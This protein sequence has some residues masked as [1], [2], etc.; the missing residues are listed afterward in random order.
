MASSTAH[1][2]RKPHPCQTR[3]NSLWC[4]LT[5]IVKFCGEFVRS[6][7][8]YRCL[9]VCPQEVGGIPPYLAGHM[10][11]QQYISSCIVVGS[12]LVWRLHTCNIKWWDRSHGRPP[13]HAC[14]PYYG[15]WSMSGRHASYWN[16]FLLKSSFRTNHS[17][18]ET[19]SIW[20]KIVFRNYP[21]LNRFWKFFG[22]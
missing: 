5:L 14:P 21:I 3:D 17:A 8:F 6:L 4:L 22:W 15:I 7:C 10:T 18:T 20:T 2:F 13:C 16:A 19:I 12:Q 9:S 1:C 11:N